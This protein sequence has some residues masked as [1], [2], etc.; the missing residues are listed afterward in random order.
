MGQADAGASGGCCAA[1]CSTWRIYLQKSY[2]ETYA[3]SPSAAWGCSCAVL[4]LKPRLFQQARVASLVF[5]ESGHRI[6]ITN[7]LANF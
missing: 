3:A 4:A 5:D 1:L 2:A 6:Q 7:A